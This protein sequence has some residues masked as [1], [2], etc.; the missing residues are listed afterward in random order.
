MWFDALLREDGRVA[1]IV[2]RGV[3]VAQ[4]EAIRAAAGFAAANEAPAAA[5]AAARAAEP[6]CEIVVALF[7]PADGA[8]IYAATA[9]AVPALSVDG[10][11]P[12]ELPQR[13]YEMLLPPRSAVELSARAGTVVLA[14]AE[15][16]GSRL[17]VALPAEPF[18]A[19]LVRASLRGFAQRAG[20]D[21][22]QWFAL[23]TAVGEAVAN[24]IEHAYHHSAAPGTVRVRAEVL[25]QSVTVC[26]EDDGDWRLQAQACEMRGRGLPLMRALVDAVD[27]ECGGPTTAVRLTMRLGEEAG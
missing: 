21:G 7:N 23:Q 15:A 3:G 4:A 20:L 5:V 22:D 19:P 8:F 26:V 12:A 11:P 16:A 2:A 25:G 1:L 14:L 6:G 17:E 9:G 18:A 10:G 27:V 24:A 13:G